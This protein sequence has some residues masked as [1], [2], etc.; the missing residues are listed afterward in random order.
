MTLDRYSNLFHLKEFKGG[1]NIGSIAGVND[2]AKKHIL[3][4]RS[5]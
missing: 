2:E 4:K 3:I 1:E 5:G